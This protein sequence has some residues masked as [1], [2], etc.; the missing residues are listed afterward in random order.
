M[1]DHESWQ[2]AR[3]AFTSADGTLNIAHVAL[4]RQIDLG[5][6]DQ[7]AIKFLSKSAGTRSLTY[8][9]L[10]DQAAWFAQALQHHGIG[11]GDRI[12]AL[13]GRVPELYATALG[14]LRHGAVFTPLF[15]A[16]GPEPIRT[17]MEIGAANV[18]VTTVALYRRKL[19]AWISELPSLKLVLL[20]DGEIG[21]EVD[22]TLPFSRFLQQGDSKHAA[23]A[24][25]KDDLALVHFTSGT[26]GKPKGVMHVH[27]A[28]VAHHVSAGLALDMREGDVYWCTA[29][30]GWVTG[31]SYG[32]IAPLTH[33]ATMIVDEAE[34]DAR[35]WYET[36]ARERVN[37]WYT[38]PTAIRMLMKAGIDL[39]RA[40]DYPSLRFM[41][42]VGEP[43][44]PSAVMWGEEAF[45][46]PF[47]DNWWQTETGSIMIANRPGMPVKPGAMGTALPGVE[48][49]IVRQGNPGQEIVVADEVGELVLRKGWPSMMRG[50]VDEMQRYDKCFSGD[51]Y[52]TGDLV[53]RDA[54]GYFWF[55]SR[56][57]DVIQSA[58]HLISPFEVESA[59]LVHAA[60]A[61]AAV[62]GLPDD[63][64]GEVVS[65][66]VSLNAEITWDAALQRDIMAHA[67]KR[68]GP[69][70]APR[71]IEWMQQLPRTRSG[72]I[73]RRLVKARV[74]GLDEGD[75]STLEA[76]DE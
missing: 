46:Q 44:N 33:G 37:I 68:L 60:V 34:F 21:E 30:P 66:Y 27:E 42:S 62:I 32:I 56:A 18:L 19:S 53:R 45:G 31:T 65:A 41:A 72:K 11:P 71:S 63:T 17:R 61:E 70:V 29:D 7:V 57:D 4:D 48:A 58:G 25:G 52:L 59:L 10:R 67:R 12:F 36:L 8:A 50:Y 35:R 47:H 1:G 16:F 64:M 5:R 51:W 55:V 75:T 9:Q 69:S 20:I 73:M 24:T 22:G 15:S 2:Q 26:T 23:A 39:V 14:T 3:D 76:N 49:A 6:G 13:L 28:V 43:L 40:H 74:L 38:A 54:E